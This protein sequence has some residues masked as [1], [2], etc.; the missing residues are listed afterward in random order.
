V[1]AVTPPAKI[2]VVLP[3]NLGDVIMA[4]PVIEGL[5]KKHKVSNISFFVE[6]GFDA[7]V[8]LNPFCDRIVQ[9][10]RKQVRELLC[11][12]RWQNGRDRLAAFVGQAADSAFDTIVNLSQPVYV[13]FL[14]SLFGG[15]NV[16]GQQYLRE[17]NHCIGDAWSQYLYAIPF[18]RMCNNLHATDV[19][20]RI[21]GVKSHDGG[22][23]MVLSDGEK[24][25][26]RQFFESR[27]I[28]AGSKVAVFQPG[29]AY[30]SKCW[31]AAH[32]VALGK[33]LGRD[34]WRVCVTGAPAERALAE[35]IV[36]KLGAV[37]VCAAGE[38][39]FRQ[40]ASLLT[41][42]SACITGDT[43]LMHAAAA[44]GITT[45]ALFGPTNP[46]ETGPYGGN[47]FVFSGTCPHM[48]CFKTECAT[49]ECM[50][51]VRPDIVYAC[52][53]DQECPQSCSCN[54]Y[55]TSCRPNGDYSMTACK[56]DMH[57]YFHEGDVCLVRNIFDDR[58]NCLP[59]TSSDY[60]R[61]VAELGAW[62]EIVS[63]MCNALIRYEG[64]R[65]AQHITSFETLKRSL[66][67][68][69]GVGAFCTAIL[70][71]RLNSIPIISPAL[72]IRQSIEVC[73]QMH[74]QVGKAIS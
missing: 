32:F 52:I 44:L 11:G 5:K 53:R 45:Y 22:Y 70:N 17:G 2:L 23:T 3:S 15:K 25:W 1:P 62:L 14:V 12:A 33:L 10:P 46:V 68:F 47:H 35:S 64:S 55:K 51:M 74:K 54:V 18:A 73:W 56:T 48:P 39:T 36:Q 8:A 42:A 27:G 38:T 37:A 50:T 30:Q 6:E 9:F 20:R 57:R 34:G 16:A 59:G 24:T 67:G 21:A 28:D 26:A 41:R 29:A 61:G 7:G 49:C 69:T 71:I 66:S 43:A 60:A 31:P 19:Y 4:T 13:S 72:A 58:W 63:D 65:S 40:S